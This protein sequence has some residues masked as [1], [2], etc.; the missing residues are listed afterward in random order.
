MK[1]FRKPLIYLLLLA[2]LYSGWQL[3]DIHRVGHQDAGEKAQCAIVLG[4][5]AWH[6][7]PSP[8]LRERLN[9]AI[10]LY[11]E[12]RVSALI[13][14]GGFGN[15][16]D[17]S[18][19]EVS[20]NYCLSEGIPAKALH[21]ES[22]SQKTLENLIAAQEILSREGFTSA[23]LVSDPWH[24]KRALTMCEDLSITAQTSAT[25]TSRFE[26][27]SSRARFLFTEFLLIHQYR[28]RPQQAD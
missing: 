4:A 26:S 13:L 16:A 25:K 8:V 5:A 12:G 14:T 27:I 10:K 19:S 7:K 21:I 22:R 3:W 18:E 9:H 23:L 6:N 2:V 17:F 28:L 1:R 11:R 24:L 15:G 20:R